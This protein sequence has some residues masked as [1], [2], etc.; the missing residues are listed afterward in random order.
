MS[1]FVT[2][3]VHVPLE[4]AI[5]SN[6][7]RFGDVPVEIDLSKLSSEEKDLLLSWGSWTKGPCGAVLRGTKMEWPD[8]EGA[9]KGVI[10]LRRIPAEATPPSLA[11]VWR[12]L[13][14]RRDREPQN[15]EYEK[16]AQERRRAEDEKIVPKKAGW[17]RRLFGQ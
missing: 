6:Y 1:A 5:Q 3:Q 13:K 4:L 11:D 2:A 14:S 10:N 7:G 8:A 16:I 17:V 9:R 12:A 15:M